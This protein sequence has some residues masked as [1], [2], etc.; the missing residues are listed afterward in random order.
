MNRDEN[1]WNSV[2]VNKSSSSKNNA[3]CRTQVTLIDFIIKL[4]NDVESDVFNVA[5]M[6][7]TKHQEEFVY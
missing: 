4:K 1:A 7:H 3:C 6:I 2:I 5:K